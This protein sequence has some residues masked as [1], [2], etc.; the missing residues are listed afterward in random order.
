MKTVTK[1]M[2]A[3]IGGA[4]LAA[5]I[6]AGCAGPR[7][8]LD[9]RP[10]AAGRAAFEAQHAGKPATVNDPVQGRDGATAETI[11]KRYQNQFK[12]PAAA[13]AGAK[14]APESGQQ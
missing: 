12:V 11:W 13:A 4:A 14:M 3:M 5:V 7:P 6:A 10:G 2:R 9:P 8:H 1:S